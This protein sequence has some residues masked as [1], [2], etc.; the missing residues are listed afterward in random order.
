[1]KLQ[2]ENIL[3]ITSTTWDGPFTKSTVQL[4]SL[5]AKENNVMFVEYPYTLKDLVYSLKKRLT[6]SSKRLLGIND[7]L[8]K[9]KTS[10]NSYILTYV[11][12]PI[13]PF[14]I[15]RNEIVYKLFLKINT[16]IYRCSLRKILK[17]LKWESPIVINAYNPIFG[18]TLKGCFNEKAIL[19]YC[20]DGFL[21]DQ[22]GMRAYKADQV[23]S[24]M[25][26]GIIVSS[27]Y[28]KEQKLN[29]NPRVYSIKNGVD[30]NLFNKAVKSEPSGL[31]KRKRIG[32]IGS[33]DQRFDIEIVKHAVANLPMFDFVFIGDIRNQDVVESLSQFPNTRFLPPVSPMEVPDLLH[34]CDVGIIPYI[35]DEINRNIY[36]LKINE[37]LAVG[38]PVVITEFARLPEFKDQITVARTKEDFYLGLIFEIENDSSSKI[39]SRNEFARKNSWEARA[40][41]FSDAIIHFLNN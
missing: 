31:Q 20:Y 17:K 3:C 38:V 18:Q 10:F 41:E 19:Y 8:E 12:P 15:I 26:D 11:I 4:M 39:K 27:E 13:L 9:R 35:C 34:D 33:I 14:N 6:I 29:F 16:G 5:L 28:L 40:I 21:T 22:R 30:F 37:Y 7:R 1:M 2:N 32:Y 36:P 23:F 24:S 25:V